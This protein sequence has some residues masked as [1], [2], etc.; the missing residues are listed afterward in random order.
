MTLLNNYICE[1]WKLYRVVST[2]LTEE[3]MTEN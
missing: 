1:A 2:Q 3:Q